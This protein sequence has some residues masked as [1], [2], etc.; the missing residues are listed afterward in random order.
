MFWHLVWQSSCVTCPSGS[1]YKT[2]LLT[3]KAGSRRKPATLNAS[4][5]CTHKEHIVCIFSSA[6]HR[7]G[8][9]SNPVC[10]T[11]QCR[12]HRALYI[13]QKS[14][15][16]HTGWWSISDPGSTVHLYSR[17]L[18]PS[19]PL[20]KH[21]MA[22]F[23][24]IAH[25]SRYF[26]PIPAVCCFYKHVHAWFP[27]SLL[28]DPTEGATRRIC[29][30]KITDLD[31]VLVAPDYTSLTILKSHCCLFNFFFHLAFIPLYS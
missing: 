27:Q 28:T 16:D 31:L 2:V 11:Q 30:L 12:K 1:G 15:E 14:E 23:P 19:L 9:P 17:A 10:T 22:N 25:F 29:R 21:A 6:H 20:S 13:S 7:D 8:N 26:L 4:S 5:Q 24:L 3:W 18:L